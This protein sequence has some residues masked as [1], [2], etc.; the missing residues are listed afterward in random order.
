MFAPRRDPE[1]GVHEHGGR[2]LLPEEGWSLNRAIH[3]TAAPT[4]KDTS[5]RFVVKLTMEGDITAMQERPLSLPPSLVRLELAG[6]TGDRSHQDIIRIVFTS[7]AGRRLLPEEGWSLSRAIHD[8]AAPI[9]KVRLEAGGV[10]IAMAH[11]L[12]ED[13]ARKLIVELTMEGDFTEIQARP[14]SLP[15]SLVQLELAGFRGE[16]GPAPSGLRKLSLC[17]YCEDGDK[18]I[19]HPPLADI[20]D[21]DAMQNLLQEMAELIRAFNELP[22]SLRVLKL[23]KYEHPLPPLPDTLETLVLDECT[24]HIAQLPNSVRSLSLYWRPPRP[25]PPLPARWP[26]HLEHLTYW[27]CALDAGSQ[28]Q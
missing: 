27:S 25:A 6:F 4:V 28:I 18:I 24:G 26:A 20:N 11:H 10:P 7:M 21:G 23:H 15:P 9:V 13:T 8:T 3:D 5:R 22:P 19:P 17:A 16:L 1:E 12:L 2:R 14:L